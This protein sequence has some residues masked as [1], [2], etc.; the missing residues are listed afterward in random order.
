MTRKNNIWTK[1]QKGRWTLPFCPFVLL[2][3][4]FLGCAAYQSPP[5]SEWSGILRGASF[6]D[7]TPMAIVAKRPIYLGAGGKII[8]N[9]QL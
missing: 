8:S 3:F 1:G 7:M 6:S 9:E 2:F 4:F 5:R